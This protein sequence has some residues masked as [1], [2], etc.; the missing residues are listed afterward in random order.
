MRVRLARLQILD[1]I[2]VFTILSGLNLD[3]QRR[4]S[5]KDNKIIIDI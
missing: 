1:D 4:Q 2:K 5:S 3:V